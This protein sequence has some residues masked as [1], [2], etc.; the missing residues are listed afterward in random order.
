M[1]VFISRPV[2][3]VNHPC[4][5]SKHVSKPTHRPISVVMKSHEQE[6]SIME[7]IDNIL[8][9][10]NND[11]VVKETISKTTV[12]SVIQMALICAYGVAYLC[13]L[14]GSDNKTNLFD[15]DIDNDNKFEQYKGHEDK[16]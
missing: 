12:G 2:S 16:D 11:D 15:H 10:M 9:D 4:C 14:F 8:H 3:H 1:H 6:R 5:T 13:S 7:T